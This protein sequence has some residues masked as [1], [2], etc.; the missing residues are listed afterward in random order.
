MFDIFLAGLWHESNTFSPLVVDLERFHAYQFFEG[1]EMVAA[2]RGTNTEIGGFLSACA[3]CNFR[4][5]PGLYAA[6]VPSGPVT[7]AAYETLTQSILTQLRATERVDGVYLALHGAMVAQDHADADGE[8][9]RRVRAVAGDKPI[10]ATFDLHANLS[11]ATFAHADLLIGYD[12]LPHVDMGMRGREAALLLRR[13]L[14]T[15]VRPRKA[16]RRLPL[17]T[18]PQQQA[19]A[20]EPMR[21]IMHE[22]HLS[23]QA[24]EL[25]SCS[26]VPGFAYADVPHL[27][28]SVLAYGAGDSA[29]HCVDH[30]ARLI[31]RRRAQFL[32]ELMAVDEAVSVA[33]RSYDGRGPIVIAEPADNVGGGSP[34]DIT[35]VLAAMMH[36]KAGSA[37]IMLWDPT[38]AATAK[39]VGRGGHFRHAVG[40]FASEY[41]GKPILIE[42]VVEFVEHVTYTRSGPYMTGQIVPMGDVAIVNC[43]GLRVVLTSERVMPFDADH[44]TVLGIQPEQERILCVKG[45]KAWRAGFGT[46][47]RKEIFVDTDGPTPSNVSRLPYRNIRRPM[48]PLD[49]GTNWE[50]DDQALPES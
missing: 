6:A 20:E 23:E 34:G 15:G 27:G 30:I 43:N 47:A 41:S 22:V 3:E 48:F 35:F 7:R 25:W 50:G 33:L 38:A 29:Q 18:V 26:V 36:A 9:L 1:E 49:A 37:V 8:L 11:D 31:W 14:A 45:A 13:V 39:Q 46:I 17:I 42:G 2:L 5:H 44:W 28:V 19:T 32:P 24:L 40:G 16:M 10:V 21:S 4:V 12:T